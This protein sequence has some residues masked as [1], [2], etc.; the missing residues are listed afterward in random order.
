MVKSVESGKEYMLYKER[1]KVKKAWQK[2]PALALVE[3]G[4]GIKNLLLCGAHD[5]RGVREKQKRR[6]DFPALCR[7]RTSGLDRVRSIL[8][9]HQNGATP[10]SDSSPRS[11]D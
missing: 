8:C 2:S 11:G 7:L 6:R 10:K 9:N 4:D 1:P 3:A 5:L